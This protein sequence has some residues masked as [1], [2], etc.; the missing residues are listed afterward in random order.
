MRARQLLEELTTE[1]KVWLGGI[2]RA[3]DVRA[4]AVPRRA[5]LNHFS[6]GLHDQD[7]LWT[8]S[9]SSDTLW[10]LNRPPLKVLE[11]RVVAW[12]NRLG[13]KVKH[14]SGFPYSQG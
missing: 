9:P 14:K 4:K 5:K 6:A 1:P 13:F 3:G 12:L 11:E 10:W 2:D 8:Y 7:Y